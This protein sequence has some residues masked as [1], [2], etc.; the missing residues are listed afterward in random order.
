MNICYTPLSSSVSS[1]PTPERSLFVTLAAQAMSSVGFSVSLLAW[2]WLTLVPPPKLVL[3]EPILVDKKARRRS[4]PAALPSRKRDSLSPSVV[5]HDVPSLTSS[6]M[7]TRRVYFIDSPAPS[8]P[9]RPT[10]QIERTPHDS[11]D[12]LD[13][14]LHCSSPMEISP[15]SSSSTLVHTYT[16]IAPQTLETCRESAIES[17]SSNNCSP[18]ASL[19]S[20]HPPQTSGRN[21]RYSGTSVTD[22]TPIIT[23]PTDG[24]HRRSSLG[25]T[26][27]WS[28]RRASGSK[29][30]ASASPATPSSG[31]A[32]AGPMTAPSYFSRKTARRVSTPVP[33]TQ[34][35][36]YPYYAQPPIEDDGYAAYLRG[37]PQFG[38]EG[39]SR[40]PT[41][42]DSEEKDKESLLFDR[43][44]NRKVNDQAQAALG[45]GRRPPILRPQRSASE[46]WA[47][48]RKPRL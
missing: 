47:A 28:F 40:S 39:I 23:G 11:S 9:S 24:K 7:R 14:P 22:I 6:P 21:R 20:S 19:S 42:S 3:T 37:L 35:Y 13:K 18:R 10:N 30:P 25:F 38:S 27:P 33:R 45:L 1:M 31:M 15:T 43:G 32:S 34:P 44:R 17:D 46:S 26:P 5:S 36:A 8:P 2:L 4:A 16:A 12:L 29:N 41:T 48:G